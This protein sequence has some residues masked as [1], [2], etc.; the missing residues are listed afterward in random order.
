MTPEYLHLRFKDGG[1][2]KFSEAQLRTVLNVCGVQSTSTW[3][4]EELVPRFG[5]VGFLRGF[6]FKKT[7]WV[8][9]LVWCY[10]AGRFG[11]FFLFFLWGFYYTVGLEDGSSLN[12][13]EPQMIWD[14]WYSLDAA[15]GAS[16]RHCEYEVST[17]SWSNRFLWDLCQHAKM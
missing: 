15:F 9:H 2:N 16:L 7:P 12:M 10:R 14:A 3:T 1:L 17:L 6:C 4:K 13:F 5:L 11:R 8:K